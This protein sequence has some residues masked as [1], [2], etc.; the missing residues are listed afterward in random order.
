MNKNQKWSSCLPD[1]KKEW[2]SVNKKFND[3][4]NHDK[5]Q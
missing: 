5:T 3:H 1:I 4:N 2:K